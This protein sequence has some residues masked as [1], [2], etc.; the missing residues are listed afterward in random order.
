MR[1][2]SL[3]EQLK[4]EYDRWNYLYTYG[5]QD[6]FWA[7]GGNLNLMRNH[8]INIKRQ[9]EEA[10]HLTDTYY[11][12]LPPAVSIDYMARPDEI[13]ANARKSLEIYKKHPDYLY[14][15]DAIKLLNAKQIKD[16]S[17]I[18]VI[19]YC[20]GL[21]LHIRD[22]DLVAMRRHEK[23][24]RYIEAFTDCRKR[25]E[26]ILADKPRTAFCE[27]GEQLPG[28]LSIADWLTV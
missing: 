21:K 4:S 17:I 11:R 9:M 26:K 24:E 7:D 23:P 19:G 3:D 5:G 10:G 28:Q 8:I 13:R 2:I 1:Q 16:T 18:N 25:V 6:P 22:D 27:D 12:E 20:Q 15:C 14:L